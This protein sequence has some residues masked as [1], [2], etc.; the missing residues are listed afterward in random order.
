MMKSKAFKPA[1]SIKFKLLLLLL[2]ISAAAVVLIT[3]IAINATQTQGQNA[4]EISSEALLTQAEDYLI[5]LTDATATENDQILSEV[6]KS[7]QNLAVYTAAVFDHPEA[8]GK[9]AYWQTQNHMSYLDDGQ[10]ANGES[11]LSSAFVPNSAEIND[12]VS[13]DLEL[14]AYLDFN[15]PAFFQNTPNIEAIYFAT[16]LDM[17][18]Y[19]PNVNLGRVLPPD[20]KATERIWF[21]GS[22]PEQNPS[23]ATWWT[24]IYVDATGL[25]LVTTAATPVYNQNHELLGVIGF[26]V[27]LVGMKAKVEET[28]FLQT[29][30]SFMMENSGQAIALPEQ[31]YRDILNSEPD[32]EN[33]SPNLLENASA[34]QPVLQAMQTGETGL[35]QVTVGDRNLFVAYA[36]LPSTGWSIGSVVEER[37]VLLAVAAMRSEMALTTRS[38]LLQRILPISLAIFLIVLLV[39]LIATNRVVNPIRRL[40]DAAQQIGSGEWDTRIAYTQDDEIGLLSASLASMAEQL[41]ENFQQ[42]ED[43]VQERTQE[44][45]RRS[46][47]VQVA[48][49]VARDVTQ[50]VAAAEG[51]DLNQLLRRAVQL[52]RD[53]FGFYH[54]GIFLVDPTGEYAEL[55]AATGEAGRV[56]LEFGHKLKVAETGIVGL[57]TGKGQPRVA[58]DVN[59]DPAYYNNP[60]LPETQSEL[61]LPLRVGESIIGALDVQSRDANAF[62]QDDITILQV[63]ADQLAVAIENTRL[64]HEVQTNL[65]ELEQFYRQYSEQA[66]KNIRET[67]KTSGYVYERGNLRP[68]L[69]SGSISNPKSNN[70]NG[71]KTSGTDSPQPYIIPLSVR[72]TVIGNLEVWPGESGFSSDEIA[73]L[74]AASSRISQAM[75]SARLYQ[76]TQRQAHQEQMLGEVTTKI[77]ET[78]SIDTVLQTAVIEMQ[79]RLDLAQVEIRLGTDYETEEA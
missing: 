66:W 56:M 16:P 74:E 40:A 27:T 42:L 78:L 41:K 71:H 5:Q 37:D 39:G 6:V 23:E 14:S 79:R 55:K 26:D 25:G 67:S 34:F 47:Q 28:K 59:S 29:G 57:A 3:V 48:A 12:R 70:G 30:Y 72:D 4:Q 68:I 33:I 60:L 62:D 75:E 18:R 35:E 11:D 49:E 63:L 61:A 8:F 77:R 52:I 44:L 38:L 69:S 45:E 51:A 53:R 31:G 76:E 43:R 20:F 50:V 7:S 2:G 9:E 65:D 64:F 10:F 24:P 36:P 73:L 32:P 13:R 1:R 46:L 58:L 19:Y 17:V 15:F 54:A 22:T 21:T